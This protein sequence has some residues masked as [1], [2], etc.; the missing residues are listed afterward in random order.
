[1]VFRSSWL[2]A[3]L[4]TTLLPAQGE[5]PRLQ[6]DEARLDELAQSIR[7]NGVIQPILAR[8]L[9]TQPGAEGND[10]F[11]IVAGEMAKDGRQVRR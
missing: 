1:M 2:S 3:L 8:R 7:T 11:E 6:I 5:K 9:R 10:R 4:A